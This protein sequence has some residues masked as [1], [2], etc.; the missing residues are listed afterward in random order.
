MNCLE[1]WK[2]IDDVPNLKVSNFGRV[3]SNGKLLQGEKCKNGYIRFHLSRNKWKTHLLAHRLVAEAFIPNP[4]N[5]PEVNHKDG[6]KSNN[7]VENLEWC[8]KGENMI[9]AYKMGLRNARGENNPASKLTES[10]IRPNSILPVLDGSLH[11]GLPGSVVSI[12][13]FASIH[14][15]RPLPA[16]EGVRGLFT[17]VYIPY[18]YM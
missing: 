2:T 6:D 5:L 9:H 3:I 15:S 13:S 7:H 10:Q 16:M 14:D 4:L 1:I 8:T 17:R 18:L 12:D 11:G